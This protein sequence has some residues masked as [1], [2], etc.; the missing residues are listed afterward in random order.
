MVPAHVLRAGPGDTSFEWHV[1][2]LTHGRGVD[3]VLGALP[4]AQFRASLRC[5][6]AWGRM[7]HLG[8]EDMLAANTFGASQ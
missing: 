1:R 7:L 6:S 3:V 8:R 5:V 2:T 4:R